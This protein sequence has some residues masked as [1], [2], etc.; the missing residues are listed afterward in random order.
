MKKLLNSLRNIFYF[1]Q[2][3]F[4]KAGSPIG[5]YYQNLSQECYK[6][7]EK[8]MKKSAIFLKSNDIRK[9]SISKAFNNSNKSSD[10]IF[11]EFGVYKGD[12]I[13]L[14]GKFLQQHGKEIYGFDSFEGLEEEWNMN[15]YNPIGRFSLNKKSPKVVKNVNL[16]IGKVQNTLDNFLEQKKDKKIIFAHMDMDTYTPTSYTLNKIKPFLQKGSIILFDEFYGF[17]NWQQHEYKAF[18]EIFNEN[19]YKYIAF[20]ES[21]VAVEIL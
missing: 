8:D 5:V 17:P 6:F 9:Y 16:I 4:I 15:D 1:I 13:N 12:S 7:F 14:F 11:L 18:T 21:E 2:N 10:D 3:Y 19:E 20:C